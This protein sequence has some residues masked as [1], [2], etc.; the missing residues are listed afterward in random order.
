[1]IEDGLDEATQ[2]ALS[3]WLRKRAMAD[4]PIA[5]ITR[6]RA[7][8]DPVALGPTEAMI[9]CPAN[10]AVPYTVP[11]IPG[12]PGF[13]TLESCLATPDVRARTEGVVAW[14]RDAMPA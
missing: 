5:A 13:E 10:H 1:M 8:L 4:R 11:A 9:L 6:S 2:E 12:A 7:I 14:R 3:A